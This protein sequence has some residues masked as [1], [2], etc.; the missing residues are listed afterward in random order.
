MNDL[1]VIDIETVPAV[2]HFA[3]L[4]PEFQSLWIAKISKTVPETMTPEES[5]KLRAGI[6]AEFG[7]VICIS[8]AYFYTDENGKRCLKVKSVYGDDEKEILT[9]FASLCNK[10]HAAKT[11]FCFAG[12]NIREFDIPYICRRML[13]NSVPLPPCLQLHDKKPWEV[14]MLDTLQHWKFGDHKNYITLNLLAAILDVPTSKTDIDGSQ[15]QEVYYIENNLQRI[16]EY[17]QRDVVAT[18]N[19]ILKFKNEPLLGE[20][21]VHYV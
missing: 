17:C 14:K 20:D 7:K 8:T 13:V 18:A 9:N 19:I 11:S 15:V 5:Y 10:F 16:V 12:H 2:P 21:A 3:D 4:S 6:L 1:L